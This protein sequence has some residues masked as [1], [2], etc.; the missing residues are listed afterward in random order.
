MVMSKR[1]RKELRITVL[2]LLGVEH[3]RERFE[4]ELGEEDEWKSFTDEDHLN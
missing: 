1:S 4:D 3:A 2:N